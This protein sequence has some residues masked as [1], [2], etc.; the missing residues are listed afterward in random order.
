MYMDVSVYS[1]KKMVWF[2][3]FCF[4]IWFVGF[5]CTI[6]MVSYCFCVLEVVWLKV[7]YDWF[8]LCLVL[9]KFQVVLDV[10]KLIIG[11]FLCGYQFGEGVLI[12]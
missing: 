6:L 2:V 12:N 3:I 7:Y 5:V 1:I 8:C 9:S 4:F 11:L 10:L